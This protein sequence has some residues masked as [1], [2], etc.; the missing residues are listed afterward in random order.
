MS[1]SSLPK[2]LVVGTS[3]SS[4]ALARRHRFLTFLSLSLSLTH[5][6]SLISEPFLGENVWAKKEM[7]DSLGSLA[8]VIVRRL[9]SGSSRRPVNPVLTR[10]TRFF[11]P[12]SFPHSFA[13]F[14]HQYTEE[15]SK[16]EFLKKC[17]PGGEYDGAIGIWRSNHSLATVGPVRPARSSPNDSGLD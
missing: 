13:S 17:A 2:V 10:A 16:D 6:L 4:L 1:S 3:S 8:Q 15:K 9:S 11:F 12:L 14:P 5:K 7:S